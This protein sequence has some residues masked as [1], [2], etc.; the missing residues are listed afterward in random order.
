M[1]HSTAE[2]HMP[3]QLRQ[4]PERDARQGAHCSCPVRGSQGVSR[5]LRASQGLSRSWRFSGGSE[6]V[7]K[8]LRAYHCVS[9]HLR[10]LQGISVGLRAPMRE[11]LEVPGICLHPPLSVPFQR[12]CH[13]SLH[14]LPLFASHTGP[15]A[16]RKTHNH[17]QFF[18]AA[19][20]TCRD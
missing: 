3:L 7:S 16:G 1:F 13:G 2:W 20:E 17:H 18:T 14:S 8:G 10:R 15:P 11:S 9:E 12:G 4:V 19:A 6:G 5:G